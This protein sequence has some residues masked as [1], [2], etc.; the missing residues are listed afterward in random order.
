MGY[1]FIVVTILNIL[2]LAA[3]TYTVWMLRGQLQGW[4]LAAMGEEIRKQDDRIRKQLER[5]DGREADVKRT[6]DANGAE[7]YPYQVGRSVNR[8]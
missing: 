7:G 2:A 1:A 3:G 4:V 6:Q 5:A 8:H